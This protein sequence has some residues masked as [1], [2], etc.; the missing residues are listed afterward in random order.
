MIT[1]LMFFARMQPP[2]IMHDLI[3]NRML[4]DSNLFQCENIY[5]FIS[6]K[7]D[8]SKNPLSYEYRIQYLKKIYPDLFLVEDSTI[9]NPFNA[10]CYL[11]NRGTD[12]IKIYCGSDRVEDYESFCKY[13]NHSDPKKCIPNIQK[14]QIYQIGLDRKENLISSSKARN[15]VKNK[16]FESFCQFVIGSFEDKKDLYNQIIKI[17][18]I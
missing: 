15:A 3:I 7:Q 8:K 1:S 13:I 4:D 14:I 2:T 10:I 9:K 6:P 18:D 16:D 5:T 12:I 17:F 11:G